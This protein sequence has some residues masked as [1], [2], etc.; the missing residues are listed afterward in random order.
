MFAT[1]CLL[2]LALLYQEE[3]DAVH[4]AQRLAMIQSQRRLL[5]RERFLRRRHLLARGLVGRRLAASRTGLEKPNG[6]QQ[7]QDTPTQEPGRAK[8]SIVERAGPGAGAAAGATSSFFSVLGRVSGIVR[9][10]D[11]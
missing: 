9:K 1:L 2:E 4:G 10:N 6:L 11:Y 8:P 5:L 7:R 3:A